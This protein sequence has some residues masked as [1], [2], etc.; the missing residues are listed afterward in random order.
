MLLRSFW[1]RL[2]HVLRT[3]ISLTIII[4]AAI[5]LEV[6]TGVMYY[7]AQNIIQRTVERLIDREMNA[8]YLC[9][10]NKLAQVEVT[11][12][13]MAW[14][15]A[16]DLAEPDSLLMATRQL[17][18]HNP[19][20]LGSS[21]TCVPFYF[22]QKGR[23]YEPYSVRR[24]DG[25][26]ESMQL[27]S[28][29]HDYTKS[30]FFTA[31]IAKGS[32]HWCEPYL[33]SD[34][35][36]AI[37]TT[38]SVPI[39]DGKGD[40]VAVVDADISLGWLGEIL[41]EGMAYKSTQRF[42]VTGNNNV[43]V[44]KD[45]QILRAA[46]EQIEADNDKKGY[47]VLKDEQ[48]KKK[49]VYYTPVGGKTEWVLINVL[50]DSDVFS[51]LRNIRMSLLFLALLG[52]VIAG[53]IVWRISRHLERLRQVNAAKDRIDNELHIASNIQMQ[54]L[55]EQSPQTK[56]DDID[57]YGLLTPAREV[58]GDIF[59]YF[60]RDEKLFFCMGDV[61]GKGVPSALLMAVTHSL[62]RA[63]SAHDNNP[64]HILQSINET[65]YE[66]NESNMF[67][68]M[69]MGI[70]DL[71]TGHLCYA[72][73]GHDAPVIVGREALPVKANIPLGLFD[74]Y[75][76]Q[77]QNTML[78]GGSMLFLYTDGLTEAKNPQRKQFGLARVMSILKGCADLSPQQLLDK[79]T[80]EVHT[81]VEGAEQSDDLTML[82]IRYIPVSH[83][84]ILE[85]QLVLQNDIH[86]VSEMN[87]FIKQITD[88][89]G[90]ESSLAKQLQLAVEEA[91]V[92]VMEYAYPLGVTGDIILEIS[93]DGQNLKFVIK[94][95]GGAFD[96]TMKEKADTTLSAEDRPI[97]GLGIL[98]VRELMDSINY[99]RLRVGD[100]EGMNVLTLIKKIKRH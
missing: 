11:L 87:Q 63:A 18:E 85:E 9:I 37:V 13:N 99:E 2:M 83:E 24:A 57:I 98:L 54:M 86:Q 45:C 76:F 25:S 94:D 14:I 96:P 58:G 69:F 68:T 3:N 67:V 40:I 91:V 88:R 78:E 80:Q 62:F 42:L 64:A 17:V 23:W 39:R 74:D 66:G 7:S 6:T 53:F 61:S 92:N 19:T 82:A 26:I 8:I 52:L 77:M 89:L 48:G 21:I 41:E 95:Y 56:R 60:I 65:L 49:H 16:D 22:P 43:L 31:P 38:Y 51:K 30:E 70:L 27:G 71:P 29:E 35:A 50:D 36:K 44:G 84:L 59:D 20:I 72:N 47:V 28:A 93:S 46:Q 32:G 34:G 73:A 1:E 33:D 100:S 75:T 10:R 4:V 90:V 55:P 15:V 5:L 81:F 97:G 79:M 12:D